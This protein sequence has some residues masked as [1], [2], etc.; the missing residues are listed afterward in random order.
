MLERTG[1]PNVG[2]SITI[3]LVF[4]LAEMHEGTDMAYICY[5]QP[6][7]ECYVGRDT[8]ILLRL[9]GGGGVRRRRSSEDARAPRSAHTFFGRTGRRTAR[10]DRPSATAAGL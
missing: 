7:Q 9:E 4:E 3:E 10:L 1:S 5:A 2:V 6:A 8:R